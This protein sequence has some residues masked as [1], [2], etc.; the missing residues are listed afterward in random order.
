M[1]N[2]NTGNITTPPSELSGA[3]DELTEE[4]R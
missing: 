2:I 1:E 4:I 3:I